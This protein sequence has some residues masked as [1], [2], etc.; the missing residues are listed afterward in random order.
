MATLVVATRDVFMYFYKQWSVD[1]SE[2]PSATEAQDEP[3][4]I[5]PEDAPLR[6]AQP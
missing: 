6:E 2:A 5:P 1:D 3:Y 4:S